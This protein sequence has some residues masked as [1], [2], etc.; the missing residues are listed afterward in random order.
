MAIRPTCDFCKKELTAFGAILFSPPTK[1][2]TV[3]KFHVCVSCYMKLLKL[4]EWK[5]RG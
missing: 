5:V 3:K 2:S 4:R 1:N